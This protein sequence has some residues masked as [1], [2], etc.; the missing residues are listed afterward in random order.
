MVLGAKE[1]TSLQ[2]VGGVSM[3]LSPRV[4]TEERTHSAGGPVENAYFQS[5]MVESINAFRN[6]VAVL[7]SD[8]EKLKA[9]CAQQQSRTS[10]NIA[11]YMYRL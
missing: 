4:E 8:V 7:H 6:E 3:A 10:G 11:C 1:E 9:S 5:S 2:N